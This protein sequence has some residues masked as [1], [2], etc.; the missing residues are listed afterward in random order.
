MPNPPASWPY[1]KLIAHRG[2]GRF[3]PENTLASM[4][5]GAKHGFTMVEYD[6]KLTLDGVAVLLHD[7]LVNR[8]SNGTGNAAEL[9]FGELAKLDF[10][11]WHS[12]EFA[13][14][15]IPTLYA[16]AAFTQANGILS[17]IEIKPHTGADVVTGT[18]VARLAR[19]LW[20]HAET[21]PLLSSF[22]EQALYAAF[23][24]APE[25]PRALLIERELP[26]DLESRL[27]RLGCTGLNINTKFAS[28]QTIE[29]AHKSGYKIGIWTVNDPRRARELL[30]WGGD[31]IFTDEIKLIAPH[32]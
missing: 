3:A 21:P 30:D 31:S 26:D 11:A 18:E 15:P 8:T 5:L 12:N 16:I 24:H 13:G 10:G 17:N 29:W 32:S 20:A 14:E 28:R 6:V 4:R 1:P 9:S 23:Q 2:A 7:D 22:S 19:Q 27:T 25:L